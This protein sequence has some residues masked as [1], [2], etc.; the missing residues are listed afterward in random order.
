MTAPVYRLLGISKDGSRYF[1]TG[2]IERSWRL[3]DIYYLETETGVLESMW[4]AEGKPGRYSY[5]LS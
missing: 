2:L 5:G 1:V 4:G 3:E